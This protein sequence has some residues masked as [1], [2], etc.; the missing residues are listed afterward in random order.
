MFRWF[1]N[2]PE[3]A[4]ATIVAALIGATVAVTVAMITIAVKDYLFPILAEKRSATKLRRATFGKYGNPLI[5]SCIALLYRLKEILDNRGHFLQSTA[6]PNPFNEYKRVS[7]LYRLCNLLGWLRASNIELSYIQ[8]KSNSHFLPIH[9]A[10]QNIEKTLADGH[11]VERSKTD[12]LIKIINFTFSKDQIN[13]LSY[14]IEIIVHRHYQG[15]GVSSA[16]DLTEEQQYKLVRE[17]VDFLCS[18]SENSQLDETTLRSMVA[19]CIREISSIETYIYRDWQH[20]LG[21]M[22]IRE[23]SREIRKYEVIGFKEFEELYSNNQPEIQKW[24]ARV[25]RL[26]DDLDVSKNDRFDNRRQQLVGLYDATYNL[27]KAI[28]KIKTS[29]IDIAEKALKDLPYTMDPKK[30]KKK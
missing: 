11:H 4:Q 10:M 8:V 15:G 3:V 30:L 23:T 9:L 2:L 16:K 27:L 21:D 20:A 14:Q 12:E 19:P 7:T 6:P 24:I 17:I 26:F 13:T 22:M 18:V 28:S 29:S 5:V 1:Y 25:K